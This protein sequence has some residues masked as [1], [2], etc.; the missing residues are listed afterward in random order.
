MITREKRSNVYGVT[1]D[2]LI[3][4]IA[5]RYGVN[6]KSEQARHTPI[7]HGLEIVKHAARELGSAKL[8]ILSF[9]HHLIRRIRGHDDDRYFID[10]QMQLAE[11]YKKDPSKT[12]LL[13]YLDSR[14]DQE[15]HV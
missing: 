9:R 3:D 5:K 2:Q 8:V 15:H 1:A 12:Y 11:V 14:K 6:L 10:L 13:Q 4:I 7:E